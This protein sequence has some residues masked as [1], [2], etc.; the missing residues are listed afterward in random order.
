MCAYVTVWT[1][2]ADSRQTTRSRTC[3]RGSAATRCPS[4]GSSSS[5]PC[6]STTASSPPRGSNGSSAGQ[7]ASSYRWSTS[8]RCEGGTPSWC[9]SFAPAPRRSRDSAA[10]I[11]G[12]TTRKRRY[13]AGRG[14]FSP[15]YAPRTPRGS[16]WSPRTCACA[17][18]RRRRLSVATIVNQPPRMCATDAARRDTG[19]RTANDRRIRTRPCVSPAPNPT[20]RTCATDAAAP[21][22]G[23]GIAPPPPSALVRGS[24]RRRNKVDARR[25]GSTSRVAR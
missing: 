20:R 6:D 22:T 2:T 25:V 4:S 15:V 5:A 21:G 9:N 24:A 10:T 1:S 13:R 16:S 23:S 7:R 19:L 18:W 12:T 11:T 14:R 8:R 17:R 3:W